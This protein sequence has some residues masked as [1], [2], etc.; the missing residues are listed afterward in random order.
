MAKCVNAQPL[1]PSHSSSKMD[2][3]HLKLRYHFKTRKLSEKKVTAQHSH[4][5]CLLRFTRPRSCTQTAKEKFDNDGFALV[6]GM[7]D[8]H[9]DDYVE[10]EYQLTDRIQIVIDKEIF[11]ASER[12]VRYGNRES[13]MSLNGSTLFPDLLSLED[14]KLLQNEWELAQGFSVIGLRTLT[15]ALHNLYFWEEYS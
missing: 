5:P 3:E 1:P 4:L 14:W 11:E 12:R 15:Y 13:K 9:E 2:T 10:L 6:L 8:H 7:P